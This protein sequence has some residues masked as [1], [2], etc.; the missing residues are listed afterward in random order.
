LANHFINL[1]C[2]A[3]VICR[4]RCHALERKEQVCQ[5]GAVKEAEARQDASDHLNSITE[6]GTQLKLMRRMQ[7]MGGR[8]R[9]LMPSSLLSPGACAVESLPAPGSEYA[10]QMAKGEL[11]RLF[12]RYAG[13]SSSVPYI[14]SGIKLEG[15][16]I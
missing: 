12:H 1:Q 11:K 15:E 4:S 8:F 3:K 16:V 2:A 7:L 9:N 13:G 10:S 5:I 14:A 6:A